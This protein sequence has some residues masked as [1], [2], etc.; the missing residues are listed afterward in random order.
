M[1]DFHRGPYETA[2]GDGEM[3]TEV[4]IP[5]RPGLGE[6]LRQGRTAGG[7][8]GRRVA[9]GAAVDVGSNGDGDRRR[10]RRAVRRRSEPHQRRPDLA[11]ASRPGTLGGAV[12]R[13]GRSPPTTATPSADTRGT[14]RLQAPPGEGAHDP[15]AAQ[16]RRPRPARTDR[17][18][19][20]PWTSR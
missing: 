14:G 8:L 9:A 19:R 2:V 5:I 17:T 12:R 20:R 16:G 10:A 6:R 3:L 11:R 15:L 18:G 13:A 7:R 1:H 4:R